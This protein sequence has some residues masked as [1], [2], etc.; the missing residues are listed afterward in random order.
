MRLYIKLSKNRGPIPFNYQHFLTG[1]VHKWIGTS[2]KEHGNRSLYC[3]SWL[4]NTKAGK[5][6]LGLTPDSYFFIS[7]YDTDLIKRITKGILESPD[8]FF[9]SRVIDVQIKTIPEFSNE[10]RFLLNSPVLIR[11]WQDRRTKHVTFRDPDFEELLTKNLKNKLKSANLSEENISIELDKSYAFPQTKLVDYRGIKNKTTL[12]PVVIKGTP[13][14]I[15]F[16]WQVGLG[17][18]TGIGFGALK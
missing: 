11:Q 4:Q 10:E 7:T 3:F 13:E 14:Q 17:H 18:S 12:A 16:A 6:G 2:N 15:A 1:V 9:G 5:N 8:V